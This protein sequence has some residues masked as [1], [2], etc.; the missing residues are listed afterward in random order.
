[1]PS[2]LAGFAVWAPPPNKQQPRSPAKVLRVSPQ[3]LAALR[4]TP[5]RP[6]KKCPHPHSGDAAAAAASPP[7]QGMRNGERSNPFEKSSLDHSPLTSPFESPLPNAKHASPPIGQRA[8]LDAVA[9]AARS[10]HRL[11]S[12]ND[13]VEAAAKKLEVEASI[14]SSAAEDDGRAAAA[15]AESAMGGPP[16]TSPSSQRSSA[17]RQHHETF[18][19]QFT[20]G[21]SGSGGRNARAENSHVRLVDRPSEYPLGTSLSHEQ[22]ESFQAMSEES[23][24][25]GHPESPQ[26]TEEHKNAMS[27][28]IENLTPQ[29]ALRIHNHS[30][31]NRDEDDVDYGSSDEVFQHA[32]KLPLKSS[33]DNSTSD[34]SK[35]QNEEWFAR[36]PWYV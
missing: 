34:D 35:D 14:A 8:L 15:G 13:A 10:P 33:W 7:V 25:Q 29:E 24:Q 5:E 23:L 11:P 36:G 9:T 30:V 18:V 2:E 20:G 28:C 12:S 21:I 26:F 19:V 31:N 22:R 1:V 4:P 3:P 17:P 16:V 32:V 27:R 6:A